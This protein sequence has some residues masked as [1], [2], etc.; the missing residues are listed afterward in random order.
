VLSLAI[1]V[2]LRRGSELAAT[3]SRGGLVT[4]Q[5][6]AFAAGMIALGVAWFVTRF[7]GEVTYVGSLGVARFRVQAVARR[8]L[9]KCCL[10]PAAELRT[11]QT[12]HFHN[13]IYTHTTYHFH[14][15]DA[16][17]RRRFSI[18]ASSTTRRAAADRDAFLVRAG[19]RGCLDAP[20]LRVV[21]RQL[22]QMAASVSTCAATRRVRRSRLPGIQLGGRIA[23]DPSDVKTLG[24][25]QGTF[26]V[27]THD[28]RG[29]TAKASSNSPTAN[30]PTRKSSCSP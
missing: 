17:G 2:R 5:T 12:R 6:L 11:S 15:T 8:R 25:S 29:T 4:F 18:A 24:L 9:A 28:A 26:S 13:G 3:L 1:A 22:Q 20:L 16:Q 19:L 7:R 10:R 23:L 27:A 21:V 30:W 14:W